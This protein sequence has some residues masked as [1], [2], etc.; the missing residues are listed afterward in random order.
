MGRK[1]AKGRR[2]IKPRKVLIHSVG[3]HPLRRYATIGSYWKE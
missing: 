1:D 3:T 2:E